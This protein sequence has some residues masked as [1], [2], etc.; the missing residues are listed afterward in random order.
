[1]FGQKLVIRVLDTAGAPQYLWDLDMPQPIFQTVQAA[2]QKEAGSILVVGPTGSGKTTTLYSVVRSMD[3]GERNIVTIEDPVEI[4][5]EGVTQIPVTEENTFAAL[6][7]S[8]LRQDPD[9]ILVGE[10]RDQETART[11]MQAAITGHLVFSSIHTRDTVGTVFRLLD[12]G[13]E[14]YL[15]AQG[16]HL[17]IAQRLV[18][19]LCQFCKK[20]TPATPQQ[21]ERAGLP[22][23][24]LKQVYRPVGCPKCLGTGY[25]GRRAFFELLS[26]TDEIRDLILR[27]PS[28]EEIKQALAK[29]QFQRLMESGYELVAQGLVEFDEIEKVVGK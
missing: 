18:R 2:I 1:M 17:V 10:I 19:Q 21:I 4:Q 6:L 24:K 25:F 27:S 11:A 8:V 23:G 7:K 9:A 13:V 26:A 15:I 3:S 5:I 29:T 12:L 14:P 28:V 20:P 16:M 22:P